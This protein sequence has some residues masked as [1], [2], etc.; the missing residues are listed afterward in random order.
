LLRRASVF[1]LPDEAAEWWGNL[2]GDF[3]WTV[4][5]ALLLGLARPL[6]SALTLLRPGDSGSGEASA[7]A[8]QGKQD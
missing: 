6:Q 2:A 7:T 1:W 4:E 8:K 5:P 3:A